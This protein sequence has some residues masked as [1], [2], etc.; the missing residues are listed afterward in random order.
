MFRDIAPIQSAKPHQPQIDRKAPNM[1]LKS[2]RATISMAIGLTIGA[3]RATLLARVWILLAMG[4]AADKIACSTIGLHRHVVAQ[5]W[6]AE[7]TKQLPA[8]LHEF[9]DKAWVGPLGLAAPFFNLLEADSTNDTLKS[10]IGILFTLLIWGLFGSAICR[11]A[12]TRMAD[13]PIPGVRSALRYAIRQRMTLMGS[14]ITPIIVMIMLFT[15]ITVLGAFTKLPFVGPVLA[16][17]FV[18]IALIPASILVL[19][20]IGFIFGWPMMMAASMAEGEDLF[21]ALSRSQTYLFQAPLSWA[22][23][24]KVGFLLQAIGYALV[25]FLS[26][27]L[28]FM[29]HSGFAMTGFVTDPAN[30]SWSKVL[31]PPWMMPEISSSAFITCLSIITHLAAC[32]PIGFAFAFPAAL[33]LTLRTKVDH[34]PP[35]EIDWPGKPE[36][37]FAGQMPSH[38]SRI[39]TV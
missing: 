28:I 25:Q 7:I 6:S 24:F 27:A 29:L 30:I 26:W 1:I 4:L 17:I 33:Y 36:G 2:D 13:A 23:T 34:I 20:L 3:I 14:I 22:I 18:P 32:W 31:P 39:E 19:T 12:L 11:I 15:A 8:K 10:L 35:T 9:F 5:R 16:W 38:E 21:D 37:D